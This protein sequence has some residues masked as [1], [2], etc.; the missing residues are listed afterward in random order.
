MG[1][2]LRDIWILHE[3]GIAVFSRVIDPN[4]APQLVSGLFSALYKFG[5]TLSH[6]GIS[7]FE[8]N[9]IRFTIEKMNHFIFITNSS[10]NVKPK[11]VMNELKK[12][13]KKFFNIY[14]EVVRE[15]WN[16]DINL[17]KNFEEKIIDSLVDSV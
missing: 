10:N 17:F 1:K 16:N 11:R 2:V 7:N 4:I 5:E 13:A 15:N 9:S 3:H 12:I 8:L 14:P 6:G